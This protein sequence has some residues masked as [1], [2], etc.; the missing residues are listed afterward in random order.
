M[1]RPLILPNH[2]NN[3][4]QIIPNFCLS[5]GGIFSP[6]AGAV[7]HNLSFLWDISGYY[8]WFRTLIFVTLV[9]S[10]KVRCEWS[11]G[12]KIWDIVIHLFAYLCVL[13]SQEFSQCVSYGHLCRLYLFPWKTTGYNIRLSIIMIMGSWFS[14]YV[15]TTCRL[16]YSTRA[17]QRGV[18]CLPGVA[19]KSS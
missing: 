12:G 15:V 2:R 19:Q 10:Q 17:L 9:I 16:R 1:L 3:T 7:P 4:K 14:C 13:C 8:E 11:A 5:K 18:G 6:P